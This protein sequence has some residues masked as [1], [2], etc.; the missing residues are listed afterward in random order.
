MCAPR[1][2]DLHISPGRRNTPIDEKTPGF[3]HWGRVDREEGEM[4]DLPGD[5]LA[6]ALVCKTCPSLEDVYPYGR[7]SVHLRREARLVRCP[8]AKVCSSD[9]SLSIPSDP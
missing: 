3:H 4:G 7:R 2:L 1:L 9:C 5:I 6:G 8:S